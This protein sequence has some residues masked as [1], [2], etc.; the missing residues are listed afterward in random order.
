MADWSLEQEQRQREYRVLQTRRR[1]SRTP[2]NSFYQIPQSPHRSYNQ[3]GRAVYVPDVAP[4]S[5][6]EGGG[7]E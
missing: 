4:E 7:E 1:A 3:D 5:P 2:E 6:K